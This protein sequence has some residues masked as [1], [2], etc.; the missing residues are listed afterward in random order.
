MLHQLPSA[1]GGWVQMAAPASPGLRGKAWAATPQGI[2]EPSDVSESPGLLAAGPSGS[3]NY[4]LCFPGY[5][6]KESEM[7]GLQYW[8]SLMCA[9]RPMQGSLATISALVSLFACDMRC[10]EL[11]LRPH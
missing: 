10:V 7:W 1:G 2:P 9:R 11:A 5:R 3:W 6:E 8:G 4:G